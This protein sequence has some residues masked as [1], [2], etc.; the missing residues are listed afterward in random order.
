[1]VSN[2]TSPISSV[3]TRSSDTKGAPANGKRQSLDLRNLKLDV[4]GLGGENSGKK[5]F[6]KI[7]RRKDDQENAPAPRKVSPSLST[8]SFETSPNLSAN[9]DRFPPSTKPVMTGAGA[10]E[11]AGPGHGTL[12]LFPMVIKKRSA[13]VVISPDLAHT[14]LTASLASTSMARFGSAASANANGPEAVS[15]TP[16]SRPVGYAWTVRKWQKNSKDGWAA[17]LVAAAS[18]GLELIPG[19]TNAE[20][21]EVV[22]EWIKNRPNLI[23]PLR[24]DPAQDIAEQRPR[25]QSRVSRAATID[26]PSQSRTSLRLQLPSRDGRPEP[27][28]RVSASSSLGPNRAPTPD[29]ETASVAATAASHLS[30]GSS[31]SDPEDSET[32]WTC[33]IWVKKTDRR[34]LLAT[35]QPAPHHPRVVA[36]LHI[37]ADLRRVALAEV[38]NESAAST[39]SAPPQG[40][41]QQPVRSPLVPLESRL[42][43]LSL[44]RNPSNPS[45]NTTPRNSTGPDGLRKA[46]IA[47]QMAKRV[48]EEVCLSEENL[49]D[50]VCVTAMWL[51]AREFGAARRKK[52]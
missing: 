35:I 4:L 18:A 20:E 31:E 38:L 29:P 8:N 14:G 3:D 45:S 5:F 37:P 39:P 2:L 32:P 52:P 23:N 1:M 24:R 26:S 49:K 13:S 21:D 16:S 7:F 47:S 25:S 41:Q 42:R 36:Q 10:V 40:A 11:S 27:A 43:T 28:R 48:K 6:G 12:G 33:S 34:Q 50:V 17:H 9:G 44:R 30:H 51:V 19:V 22:F 46:E 15:L